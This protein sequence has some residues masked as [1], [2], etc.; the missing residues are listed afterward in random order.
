MPWI[1]QAK[2]KRGKYWE[3]VSVE[4]PRQVGDGSPERRFEYPTE[5]AAVKAFKR[6]LDKH[7]SLPGVVM[8]AASGSP[9]FLD[10][11]KVRLAQVEPSFTELK[12]VPLLTAHYDFQAELERLARRGK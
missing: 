1:I 7:D 8:R 11:Y 10:R 4:H 3:P 2:N 6:F 9:R 5:A 12:R